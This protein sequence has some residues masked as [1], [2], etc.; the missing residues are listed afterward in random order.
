MSLVHFNCLRGRA[1]WRRRCGRWRGGRGGD[2]RR[3]IHK[4]EGAQR[5]EARPTGLSARWRLS[6]QWALIVSVSRRLRGRRIGQLHGGYRRGSRR[7][8]G[9]RWGARGECRSRSERRRPLGWFLDTGRRSRG[10]RIG[11]GVQCG[12]VPQLRGG[13]R[14]HLGA[15]RIETLIDRRPRRGRNCRDGH[16]HYHDRAEQSYVWSHGR[17]RN[18]SSP[19]TVSNVTRNWFRKV[20]PSSPSIPAGASGILKT[21][22][23]IF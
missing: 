19:F 17:F 22:T 15:R 12:T 5:I 13:I 4:T 18:C 11:P 14:Q 1:H 8:D 7:N 23:R 21:P 10:G 20:S 6:R 3:T 16:C 2:G 9:E